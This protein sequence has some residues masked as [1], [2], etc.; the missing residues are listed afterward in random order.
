MS[1]PTP[2]NLYIQVGDV[3]TFGSWGGDV[4]TV[5]SIDGSGILVDVHNADV[6]MKIAHFEVSHN[7][8]YGVRRSVNE[9]V[10]I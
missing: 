1:L 4:G 10:N 3:I 5:L 8:T 7:H 9:L 6:N 2:K